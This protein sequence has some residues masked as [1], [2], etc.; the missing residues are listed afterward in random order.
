MA[1]PVEGHP[2]PKQT[3]DRV[4]VV[5]VTPGGVVVDYRLELDDET[6]VTVDLRAVQDLVDFGELRSMEDIY[7]TY[8]RCYA[9]IYA[10]NLSASLD[11]KEMPFQCVKQVRRTVDD[12]GKPI[13]DHLRFDFQFQASWP[14][15]LVG[16]HQF[17]FREGNYEY[18]EGRIGL[19][20]REQ[21]P[22]RI[23]D[24]NE[25]EPALHLKTIRDLK[26][27]E[28]GRRRLATATLLIAGAGTTVPPEKSESESSEEQ[29][30]APT[31]LGL[32]V[33]P[34]RGL[35]ILLGM[36]FG[37]GAAHAL[38]PGHGKT[39]VAA[40]LVGERGTVWHALVLGLV[41]TATHTGSVIILAFI[42]WQYYPDT[43]P[44]HLRTVLGLGGGLMVAGLGF[45][46]MLR[47]LSGQADHIH[48]AGSG[49]HHHGHGLLAHTHDERGHAHPVAIQGG[50]WG[51]I[52]L[53]ISGGMIPC[54]DAIAMFGFAI[55]A[56]R[57]WLA[58]DLLLAF[59]AGLASILIVIGILVV[60]LKGVAASRWEAR[61]SFRALPVI[62]AATVTLLGL[63]LCYDSIHQPGDW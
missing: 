12:E 26:P 7:K 17:R 29:K 58:L 23:L 4:L 39:L 9:S 33:D 22:V 14:A 16:R 11:G 31:L 36:A 38:T 37:F 57:M 49:H 35:W 43:V 1:V 2:V 56:K 61:R 48:L 20:L 34:R 40:Y 8:M 13:V 54:W 3:Y 19:S 55:S 5:H 59:S 27:G 46:L 51:L 60:R 42:L 52:V 50:F 45:W 18:E 25:P 32:L 10:G 6:L 41:T 53:G 28:D 62:S 47:R 15:G 63:W 30:E 24:K 21:K 44:A